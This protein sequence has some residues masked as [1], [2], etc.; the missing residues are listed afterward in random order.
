MERRAGKK[1]LQEVGVGMEPFL[2]ADSRRLLKGLQLE[3]KKRNIIPTWQEGEGVIA[4][5]PVQHS[6]F[7]I[8]A[9]KRPIREKQREERGGGE[10]GELDR[11]VGE[12]PHSKYHTND[13]G[14]RAESISTVQAA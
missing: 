13:V 6:D 4:L 11:P 8:A 5:G 12:V 9:G 10:E 2:P 3:V 14:Y 1:T 7:P